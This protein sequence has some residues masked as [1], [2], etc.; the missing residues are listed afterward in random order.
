MLVTPVR[1]CMPR[2][3][4][5]LAWTS[6]PSSPTPGNASLTFAMVHVVVRMLESF[7]TCFAHRSGLVSLHR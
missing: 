1:P 2:S 4:E 6:A 5:Q 3:M 7:V